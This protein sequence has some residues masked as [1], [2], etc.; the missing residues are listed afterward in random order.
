MKNRRRRV[1]TWAAIAL[2]L[3]AGSLEA[4]PPPQSLR[5]LST[6]DL[7]VLN[8]PPTD[9]RWAS[10]GSVFLAYLHSGVVEYGLDGQ[11]TR[12]RQPVP[13]P[14]V[15]KL[16]GGA[17][18]GYGALATS[19]QH[20]LFSYGS[21]KIGRRPIG[22]PKG[23]D[24]RFDSQDFALAEDLDV[25]GDRL[26]ILGIRYPEPEK[27]TDGGIAWLGKVS[28]DAADFRLLLQDENMADPE[29]WKMMR[30]GTASL[31]AVRFLS[32][33]SF[34]VVP[35]VQPGVYLF[36]RNGKLARRWSSQEV[37]LTT[38]CQDV[39]LDQLHRPN[40]MIPWLN[41]RRALDDVLPL[42]E[43][44]GLLVRSLGSDGKIHWELK[45]LRPQ[46]IATYTV[47]LVGTRPAD[48]LRGDVRGG[49]IVLLMSTGDFWN[50]EPDNF[51]G[52]LFVAQLSNN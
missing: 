43:G 45:V 52:R 27:L 13:P 4:A 49:K 12:L 20:L 28:D 50:Q 8:S 23:G 3:S 39:S 5:I 16:G 7:P 11:L 17:S 51:T 2:T 25:D 9:I 1:L 47:P 36:N 22:G 33:G 24:V 41:Q 35:G 38:D 44:P 26:L 29:D 10:D 34:L 42:P 40:A 48:R 19:P 37:G 30:C 6:H 32:D 15:L 18:S 14:H 46:G 31:G 21:W